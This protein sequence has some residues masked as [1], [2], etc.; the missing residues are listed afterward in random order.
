MQKKDKRIKV[1]ER[2]A[3]SSKEI[4]DKFEKTALKTQSLDPHWQRPISF[5][6]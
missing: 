3:R 6:C 4:V 2:Q 1:K 5:V